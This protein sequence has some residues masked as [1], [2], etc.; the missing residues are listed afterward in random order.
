MTEVEIIINLHTHNCPSWRPHPHS[1]YLRMRIL[2]RTRHHYLSQSP[3]PTSHGASWGAVDSHYMR[4]T[5]GVHL[6]AGGCSVPHHPALSRTITTHAPPPRDRTAGGLTARLQ[7]LSLTWQ[8]RPNFLQSLE[9]HTSSPRQPAWPSCSPPS[10]GP[11]Q[12]PSPHSHGASG[13]QHRRQL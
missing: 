11:S 6:V 12:S 3:S 7:Q 8:K 4:C 9:A 2:L 13:L 10:A 1:C 5:L